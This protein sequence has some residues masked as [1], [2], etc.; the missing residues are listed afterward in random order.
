MT[1]RVNPYTRLQTECREWAFSVTH[2]RRKT[3]F[4]Y[5]D[6]T[7]GASWALESLRQ[8]VLAADQL[9]FDV[10][11]RVENKSLIAEYT[12]RPDDVPWEISV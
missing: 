2:P 10:R 5:D 8:R 3:L 9:G 12:K 7:S 11:L 4:R 6:V 1:K